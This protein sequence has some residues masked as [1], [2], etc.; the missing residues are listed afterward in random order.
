M[1]ALLI[2]QLLVYLSIIGGSVFI[3][4]NIVIEKGYTYFTVLFLIHIAI[5]LS[6][7]FSNCLFSYV[8]SC[9]N[10]R[11]TEM[12]NSILNI[13]F[14]IFFYISCGLVPSYIT[15]YHNTTHEIID[16]WSV[17][18]GLNMVTAFYMCLFSTFSFE[19][20]VYSRSRSQHIG[21]I[22]SIESTRS[23]DYD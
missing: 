17:F 19:Y 8:R 22:G 9:I 23:L 6:L 14:S 11:K 2:L 21:S 20:I 5:N 15:I 13:I 7:I 10:L 16:N 1:L 4:A 12:V 18:V 3:P